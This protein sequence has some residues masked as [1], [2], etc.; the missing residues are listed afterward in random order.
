[1]LSK[2]QLTIIIIFVLAI[3]V[4]IYRIDEAPSSLYWDEVSLGYNAYSLFQTGAD[5]YGNFLPISIRSFNDYKPPLYAYLTAPVVGLF[6]LSTISVRLISIISGSITVV[7]L[8][9]ISKEVLKNLKGSNSA[10]AFA[11]LILA[12]TPWHIQFSRAAFE[13]NL[14]LAFFSAAIWL[15]L[16]FTNSSKHKGW[17]LLSSGLMMCMSIY[18]YHSYRILIPLLLVGL[19]VIYRS[20]ILTTP[21]AVLT[22][23]LICTV[24]LSPLLV[25]F[26]SGR[27]GQRFGAVTIFSLENLH[28]QDLVERYNSLYSRSSFPWNMRYSTLSLI[29][30]EFLTNYFDHFN[31]SFL[32]LSGD[33]NERHGPDRFGLLLITTLPL[34]LTGLVSFLRQKKAHKKLILLLLIISPIPS[35]VAIDAPHSIRSLPLVLVFCILA[36]WGLRQIFFQDNSNLSKALMTAWLG[37]IGINFIWYAN[38]YHSVYAINAAPSWQASYKQL[39]EYLRP[40]LGNYSEV[41]VTTAYDQPYIYFAFYL[42][43]DPKEYQKIADSGPNIMA[44]ILFRPIKPE[45][46]LSVP[47][48]L[49]VMEPEVTPADAVIDHQIFFPDGSVAF[50]L[51]ETKVNKDYLPQPTSTKF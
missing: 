36:S 12:L 32:F 37:L 13:A 29:S 4:R 18:S 11:G 21:R 44:N 8:I 38:Y 2:H 43:V 27:L 48:S 19:L 49:V 17:Y 33:G 50:N 6:G 30:R 1:M 14:G 28:D 46:D 34:I 35:A 23:L 24:V 45:F 3:V 31:L 40:R 51:L 9:L 22:T 20:I 42:P 7:F 39:V 15:F 16:K 47:N 25:Q 5:E 10:S 26:S 41:I